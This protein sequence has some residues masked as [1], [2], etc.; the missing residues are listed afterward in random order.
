MAWSR[1]CAL[2]VSA[3]K[4]QRPSPDRF[5][6]QPQ[7]FPSNAEIMSDPTIGHCAEKI[8]SSLCRNKRLRH[9]SFRKGKNPREDGRAERVINF[10]LGSFSM[11]T[12][13]DFQIV[14]GKCGGFAVKIEN[15]ERPQEKLSFTLVIAALREEPWVG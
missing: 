13:I 1:R 11:K 12:G 7:I 4:R 3:T 2:P 9:S 10:D 5:V 8:F 6:L 15:P 14:C